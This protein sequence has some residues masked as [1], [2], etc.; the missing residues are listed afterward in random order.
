MF[1]WKVTDEIELQLLEP[2]HAEALFA[3]TDANR[4]YLRQWLPWLD[5]TRSVADSSKLI[6]SAVRQFADNESLSP[7]WVFRECA[8]RVAAAGRICAKMGRESR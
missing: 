3:V 6:A 4:Q 5:S 2:R 8:F 1:R 7:K